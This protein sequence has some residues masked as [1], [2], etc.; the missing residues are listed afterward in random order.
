MMRKYNNKSLLGAA[1]ALLLIAACAIHSPVRAQDPKYTLTAGDGTNRTFELLYNRSTTPQTEAVGYCEVNGSWKLWIPGVNP[2]D[3]AY[4]CYKG[5]HYLRLNTTN[6]EVEDASTFDK[7][8]VW[9]RSDSMTGYYY[10]EHDNYR[11]YLKGSSALPG[12]GLQVVKVQVGQP[13][14]GITEWYDWDLGAA[15]DEPYEVNGQKKSNYFWLSW[16]IPEGGGEGGQWSLSLPWSS[17]ERPDT[18]TYLTQNGEQWRYYCYQT[19][20]PRQMSYHGAL[21]LPVQYVS[22]GKEIQHGGGNA[23]L[24]ALTLTETNSETPKS[25]LSYGESLKATPTIVAAN[26][27]VMPSYDEYSEETQRIG[28]NL[29]YKHRNTP[30]LGYA[31]VPTI[32]KHIYWTYDGADATV[33]HGETLP[34]PTTEALTINGENSRITYSLDN[35]SRRYLSVTK[36]PS[37]A[38]ATVNCISVPATEFTAHLTVTVEFTNGTSEQYTSDIT[39]TTTVVKLPASPTHAPVVRGAVFGGGRMANVGGNTAVTVHNCDSI[40]YV[41]G[42]NDISGQV[43][44]SD[45]SLVTLGSSTYT[46]SYGVHIGSVYGGGNGYYN[47]QYVNGTTNDFVEGPAQ[48]TRFKGNVWLWNGTSNLVVSNLADGSYIPDIKHTTVVMDHDNVTVDTLFGGARNAFLS[49]YDHSTNHVV[50]IEYNHGTAYAVFGGNNVGG[51][52]SDGKIV[53]ITVNNTKLPADE[54]EPRDASVNTYFAGFGRDFGI[55]YLFG[56]GN[57]VNVPAVSMNIA[58]GRV[59][60]CFAGGNSATVVTSTE[61]TVNCPSG[62]TKKFSNNTSGN[63][64]VGGKHRYNVRCLFGGNNIAEMNIVP[65]L[66]LTSGGIG[67]VYGGGNQG[68]M[69][70]AEVPT[71]A[72]TNYFTEARIMEAPTAL[73]TKVLVNSADMEIDYLYGGCRLA[74]ITNSTFVKVTNGTIG[75]LFGGSNIGGQIGAQDAANEGTFVV[76]EGGTVKTN[77]FGGSNGYYHCNTNGKYTLAT[78]FRDADGDLFDYYDDYNGLDIPTHQNTHLLI[79]GGTVNGNVYG[80]ANLANVGY[81]GTR[82]GTVH[83]TME[84]GTVNGNVFGGGN[85]ASI[86]GLSYLFVTGNSV[87]NKGLYAGNDRVGRIETFSAKYKMKKDGNWKTDGAFTA[88]DETTQLNIEVSS[89]VWQAAY[90]SYVRIEGSPHIHHVYGSGNGAYNYD[91]DYPQYGDELIYCDLG[92][93]NNRPIQ[94]SAFIDLHP[95]GVNASGIIDTVFGGGNGVSV[96]DEVVVLLNAANT[97]SRYVGTIFGGNNRDVMAMTANV[98]D[99]RLLKGKV[100]DVYG[101]GNAGSMENTVNLA[102][103]CGKEVFGVSTHVKV[104]SENA[105][106]EGDLYGGCRMADVKGMAYIEVLNTHDGGINTIYGGNNISGEIKGNTRVDISGGKVGTIYGGSNGHYD[107]VEIAARNYKVYDFGQYDAEHPDNH[108]V[109]TNASGSPKVSRTLVNVFGGTIETNVYGGGRLGDCDTTEV[110]VN[111]TVCS[112]GW[113]GAIINGT[114]YGGGEGLWENLSLPRRGNVDTVCYVHLYH[115]TAVGTG[116]GLAQAY[117][118]GRGGN[119]WNTYITVYP[120]WEQPFDAIYGGCWGSDVSGT[121]HVTMDG[122]L[123]EGALNANDV[124]GGNDFTGSVYNSIVTINSGRYTNVYGCGNGDYDAALYTENNGSHNYSTAANQLY[125]PNNEFAEVNFNDGHI[126]NN[127]YGGGKMGTTLR[128]LRDGSGDYALDGNGRKQADTNSTSGFAAIDRYSQVTVNVRGGL[129]SGN[130]YA[131]AAGDDKQLVYGLKMVNMEDGIVNESV[132]GGSENVD[133]GYRK[134][135]VAANNTTLRPSSIVNIT[136]GHIT[137]HVFGGGYRGKVYGSS[138]VNLGVHAIDTCP[139]WSNTYC[140]TANAYA[141]L[142]PTLTANQLVLVAS[143]Y[144]GANW[145]TNTGSTDFTIPGFAG[146]ENRIIIDGKGYNT[147]DVET[148]LPVF[149]IANSVI[150]SGTSAKGGDVLCRIDILN[151]GVKNAVCNATRQLMS[152]QRAHEL[153]LN[154]TAIEYVGATD[155]SSAYTSVNYTINRIDSINARGYNLIELDAPID[156]TKSLNFWEEVM[157]NGQLVRVKKH[158]LNEVVATNSACDGGITPVSMCDKLAVI[159]P[160]APVNP[161]P[162]KRHTALLINSG[163]NINLMY[164]EGEVTKYGAVHGFAYL[165]AP[166]GMNGTVVAMYKN[167]A[168]SAHLDHDGFVSSCPDLNKRFEGLNIWGV[169]ADADTVEYPYTNYGTSYRTWSLNQGLRSR[170]G[171]ILAHGTPSAAPDHVNK[172]IKVDASQGAGTYQPDHMVVSLGTI[173][174]PQTSPGHYYALTTESFVLTG[175]NEDLNLVDSAWRPNDWSTLPDNYLW[176][177]NSN[178]YGA[179]QS[180]ANYTGVREIRANPSNTFGLIVAAGSN[181]SNTMPTNHGSDLPYTVI[182]G[183]PRVNQ[184]T[185][186]CTTKV[187]DGNDQVTPQLDLFLTYNNSF[188]HTFIGSV[189]FV[190]KEYDENGIDIGSDI[191]VEVIVTTVIREFAPIECEVL[192]MN[193][194]GRTNT[195]LRKTVLPATMQKRDLYLTYVRWL[196][197]TN[198]GE[199]E[200]PTAENNFYLAK[201]EATVLAEDYVEGVAPSRF[202][203]TV[204]PTDD[205]SSTL[206]SSIGWHRIDPDSKAINLWDLARKND[207]PD[208]NKISST[209]THEPSTYLYADTVTQRQEGINKGR[210][211]FVGVLD[212]RGMAALNVELTFNGDGEYGAPG[213]KGYV[214]KAIVGFESWYNDVS[215]GKFELTIYVKTR[216]GGDTIYIATAQNITDPTINN[217]GHTLHSWLDSGYDTEAK[218]G[219]SPNAYVCTFQEAL[220]SRVYEEGDVIAVLDKVTITGSEKTTISGS[221]FA[222]VPVIRYDGHHHLWPGEA[223]VYRGTMIEVDGADAILTA[224]NIAFDGQCLSKITFNDD[225]DHN[226]GSASDPQYILVDDKGTTTGE[227][228]RRDDIYADTNAVYGPVIAVKNGGTMALGHGSTVMHNWNIN[229]PAADA[230]LMGTISVTSNGVLKVWNNL[231]IAENFSA[232]LAGAS[233]EH[234]LNGAVYVDGGQL[235]ISTSNKDTKM[236]ITKNY[237]MPTTPASNWWTAYPNLTTPKRYKVNMEGITGSW[238]KANVFLMRDGSGDLVDTK[239]DVVRLTAPMTEDSRISVSKWFPGP[240]TRDTIRIVFH[241]D[242][243]YLNSAYTNNNFESDGGYNIFY[244]TGV[245]SFNIYLHRC[246]TFRQQMLTNPATVLLNTTAGGDVLADV[247]MQYDYNAEATCPTGGERLIYRVQ[248][249][250]FPYLYE[251]TGSQT[252]TLN[253]YRKNKEVRADIDAGFDS[254]FRRAIADTLVTVHAGMSHTETNK[255]MTYNVTATDLA[256]CQ[257]SKTAQITLEKVQTIPTAWEVTGTAANWTSTTSGLTATGTRQYKAIQLTPYVR[258]DRSSGIISAIVDGGDNDYVFLQEGENH[259]DFEG[260]YFCEGDQLQLGT[261]SISGQKFIMWDFDPFYSNPVTYVVPATSTDIIAYY[262]PTEYWHQHINSPSLAGAVYDETAYY[263]AR[264]TPTPAY[265]STDGTNKAGY[266]TTYHGDVHIYDENGLAWFISVV[267]GLHGTQARPFYFNKVF[268]HKKPQVNIGTELDPEMVDDP[269]D[270]KDYLWTPVGTQQHCFRG[271]FIGVSADETATTALTGDDSVV[272]RNIIV[273]EPE[274]A[275]AG[276]FGFLDSAH[277]VRIKLESALVRGMQNVGTFAAQSTQS[278]F[279]DCSVAGHTESGADG[280]TT[281]LTTHHTSGGFVGRSVQDHIDNSHSR[282]KYVGDAVYSG[283]VLGYGTGQTV[284]TNTGV[285]NDNRME[286]LYIGGLA[287][288]LNGDAPVQSKSNGAAVMANNYVYLDVNGKSQRVGGLVGYATNSLIE[289]NYVHGTIAGTATEGGVGA[290]LDDGSKSDHNYYEQAAVDKTVGQ[291]RGNAIVND[292]SNFSGQGNQVQLG[293]ATYGVNNLTRVLNLW[294]RDHGTNYRTW[295]SDLENLNYG[296]PLYGEPDMIPVHDEITY[297][298]CDSIEWEGL[299]YN[300]TTVI[301]SHVIDSLLMIDSTSTLTLVVHH[302]TS[303]QYADTTVIGQDY[304]GYG[305][306][307]SAAE[308]ELLRLTVNTF[309]SATIVLSDTLTTVTG[310]DSIINLSLTVTN[311]TSIVNVEPTNIKV[312]PNPTTS[313]VTIETEGL[314]HVELY[315]NEGRRL[316]D[317][318]A[319]NDHEITIDV[320][321]F[322]TGAYFLR[323]HRGNDVTIQKLIKK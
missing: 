24:Q 185:N 182:S 65:T 1:S 74:D 271:D 259:H 289:N 51:G 84:G 68:A 282:A 254:S 121:T 302:S 234:P 8:C 138:Y 272:I 288:Y 223:G 256:G 30:G 249:G 127:L 200:N 183:T 120:D 60:T 243:T 46:T 173:D 145:G 3:T 106:V 197:T 45:G 129:I 303:E 165:V 214:G 252:R 42:G 308:L 144:G 203:L 281:I 190:L 193:N 276:F 304:S 263:Q 19:S 206:S 307:A 323:I 319:R 71:S 163:K 128:Y 80:G 184:T 316:Q 126:E 141:G 297:E 49:D 96:R 251:W 64:W 150:G 266:V 299:L 208:Y 177:Q 59:D 41:Y 31:G 257:V 133:D 261:A 18:K 112:N 232:T 104:E 187:Q 48:G 34:T 109:A 89:G 320:S 207:T 137:S 309:G 237:L 290:V 151:Y 27:N 270:M 278:T 280:T 240:T 52:L 265:T 118:G 136:G 205:V 171:V 228:Y 81:S 262:G 194:E 253:T 315:D 154:N 264:P 186:F 11:Y 13:I 244:N 317:Y 140:G 174:L 115:A 199:D 176:D 113:G 25:T 224:R 156:N 169:Y 39:V 225:N 57:R 130:V 5:V 170:Q 143:V 69:T 238:T 40:P 245:S 146:G 196:P 22:H 103:R 50:D 101:G 286:G 10:Q 76:L 135:C 161:N 148:M 219:K 149:S 204:Y 85:M 47:Y 116:I 277:V 147:S 2:V 142:K 44:G 108:L 275:N 83:L 139:V 6:V 269:Y 124:F 131:G 273:D 191:E 285:R 82:N 231:S 7:Y 227:H 284:V 94:S 114:I 258:A 91:G 247:A 189:R 322:A 79:L 58:G 195:F 153:W 274:L 72:I 283:G 14:A 314:S 287:G 188:N 218:M 239:T 4:S 179:W 21:F 111:D 158:P 181:F 36:N 292:N 226:Y 54:T 100:G 229:T 67:T 213:G 33:D 117:G 168:A 155:A 296:Y 110:V 123:R 241:S 255:V 73:G 75:T 87:I 97:T 32:E 209:I 98:P 23:S 12:T 221:D 291:R 28:F 93:G 63:L 99:V 175:D 29:S 166:T 90:S 311:A 217:S 92:G 95:S 321:S 160:E 235:Q 61:V 77:V 260:Y 162:E 305:F 107:Y 119:V 310:C 38:F 35:K 152:V 56:G 53:D 178:S 201:D 198:V 300:E 222:A 211:K 313:R 212:G 306:T 268:L 122:Q 78:N 301:N 210:G 86:Y 242:P 236:D 134:E 132:Y 192:A 15:V 233:T 172:C 157:V 279:T 55:R 215:Q 70:A 250:F 246:A 267:N 294:V 318:H 220:S 9:S 20:N 26:V 164:K 202:G 105:I 248:G 16:A 295:R 37:E 88:T 293:T 43:L 62:T 230:S 159:S 66:T 102:D 312:Y 17:Y 216:A 180:C 167:P 125:V 298:G